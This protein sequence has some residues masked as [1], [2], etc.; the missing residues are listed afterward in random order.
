MMAGPDPAPREG[1]LNSLVAQLSGEPWVWFA[2]KLA[3]GLLLLLCGLRLGRWMANLQRRLLLRAH[4]DEILAE[5]LRNVTYALVFALILVS[6]LEIAGFPTTSLLTA[7]GAAGLAIGLALKD[8]VAHI[9]AGVLLVALRPFRAGDSVNIAGQEGVVEGI[10]M[11]QTRI[12]TADNREIVLM[13]A[14]V[15]GAPIINYSQRAM[16][17]S[18]ITL[19]LAHESDLR[20]V[21]AVARE[22]IG[23]DSRIFRNPA[24]YLGATEI[25]EHGIA[26]IV[27]VWSSAA[28]MGAV[29]SEL[30]MR[31]QDALRA[32]GI[33]FAKAP[34]ALPKPP[35]AT[36]T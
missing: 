2:L 34:A 22:A 23:A 28:E 21:F 14:A 25:T 18:D 17:R 3:A 20:N 7:L 29:R 11:F 35:V 9:A 8:S 6:A 27:Q 30:L 19:T 12:H 32:R 36:G 1:A 24:P 10:F 13:N 33:A 15:I 4:V 16:R 5:F 26:L 31:L